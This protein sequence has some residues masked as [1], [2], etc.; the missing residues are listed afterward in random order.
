[1]M[2]VAYGAGVSL[3][4]YVEY[5]TPYLVNVYDMD[6]SLSST[7]AIIRQYGVNLVAPIGGY[8][9]DKVL[10][11]TYKWYIIGFGIVGVMYLAMTVMFRET[12]NVMVVGIYTI[13]VCAMIMMLYTTIWS[14][15][16]E[17]HV[18]AMVTATLSGI[19]TISERII[20]M[21][22]PATFGH[23]MDTRE[24]LAA[25][26][27]IFLIIVA[28]CVVGIL[29]GIWIGRHH[30]KCLAGLRSFEKMTGMKTAGEEA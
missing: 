18:P 17:L 21:F 8:I 15:L 29:T 22:L 9:C 7:L 28:I 1:M 24:P 11:A 26:N 13:L 16:R 4:N 27:D 20:Q 3:Y 14:V 12:S 19:A 25:F 10:K 30:K 5:F 2:F 6:P 23:F